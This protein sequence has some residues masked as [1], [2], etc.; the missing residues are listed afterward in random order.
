MYA[1]ERVFVDKDYP[2]DAQWCSRRCYDLDEIWH[3]QKRERQEA[4]RREWFPPPTS[5][6]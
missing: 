3:E 2:N 6:N 1:G 5:N 4:D